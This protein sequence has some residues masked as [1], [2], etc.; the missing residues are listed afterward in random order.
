[1]SMK[2]ATMLL[3]VFLFATTA[4]FAQA[5]EGDKILGVWLSENKNGK[6]QIYKAGNKYF[7]K[8]IWGKTMYEADGVTSRK[9]TKN[10][11]ASLRNRNLKDL[12]ILTDM[13]YDDGEWEDG[14]VYDP[15]KGKTY[16]CTMKLNGNQLNL[17]GYV[18]VSL[19]GRT[20][21]WTRVQ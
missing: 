21:V 10:S 6:I 11:D 16:S 4:T 8:L 3:T 20:S 9:D 1:M 15:E 17:R 2:R 18:G 5:A 14:K 19:L 7:G 12:V 13:E